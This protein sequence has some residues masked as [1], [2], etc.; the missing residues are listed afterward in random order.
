MQGEGKSL[1]LGTTTGRNNLHHKA[2]LP[3]RT[4]VGNRESFTIEK[5]DE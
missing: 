3:Q 5:Y 1:T 4:G 2:G